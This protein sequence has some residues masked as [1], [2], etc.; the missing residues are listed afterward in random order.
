MAD[1]KISALTTAST[2]LAGTEVL[3]IVQSGNTVKV[4]VANLTAGRAVSCTGLTTLDTIGMSTSKAIG[5]GN[6][7]AGNFS[8]FSYG[9]LTLYDVDGAAVLNSQTNLSGAGVKIQTQGVTRLWATNAGDVRVATGN[10]VIG[11]SGKGID[12]SANPNPAGMTSELLNDYE[13]GNWTPNQ[14]G[15]CTVVGTFSSTGTY[16][17][18]GNMVTLRGTMSGS[19]SISIAAGSPFTT[20]LPFAPTGGY[21][22]GG[23]SDSGLAA[24]G[25]VLAAS[26]GLFMQA[27]TGAVTT[28]FFSITYLV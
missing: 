5:S 20:S 28:I 21:F 3:P 10:L 6:G 2:P 16:T 4:P 23:A 11:T 12:F 26:S 19:T 25:P 13:E 17:K 27:A 15:A 18:V 24:R 14:G 7:Y 8:A 1:T 22:F 9:T